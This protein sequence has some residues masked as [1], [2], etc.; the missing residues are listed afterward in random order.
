MF[1]LPHIPDAEELID[2]AFRRGSKKAKAAYSVRGPK[3]KRRIKSE[4]TR[5]DTVGNI[6]EHELNSIVKSF[7]SYEQ[8][9]PFHQ[10][11]I[12]LKVDRDRYKK[13]LGSVHGAVPV[14]KKLRK[15]AIYDIK[16]KDDADASKH[17]LGKI[18]GLMKKIMPALDELQEI[19]KILKSFP[20]VEDS[21]TLVIAGYPNVGKSTFT[22]NLTGSKIKV[23]RYP[24]TTTEILIG[25][26]ELKYTRYQIIDT[27]GILDRPME[28]R[29]KTELKA[30][31]AIN[32]LA[33]KVLFIVDPTEDLEK[34][35]KLLS[36]IRGN[37]PL[38]IYTAVNKKDIASEEQMKKAADK[39][40]SSS[41]ICANREE[42]CRNLFIKIFKG[43][44]I[45]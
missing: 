9:P 19:K 17:Y 24:F 8:L 22:K 36:E 25:H 44:S 27:P 34:Q 1:S 14:L 7:P 41:L 12:D 32:E 31:L 21:P 5:V 28:E 43:E 4:L 39:F 26:T 11:L 45:K 18:S 20:T 35:D 10:K 37:F 2:K 16:R 3:D 23:A 13:A 33:D 6:I 15:Q 40:K 42:D 38:E 30:V 29:N